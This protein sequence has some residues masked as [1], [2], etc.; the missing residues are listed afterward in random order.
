MWL[1]RLLASMPGG[2]AME[3]FLGETHEQDWKRWE[4]IQ[5]LL[6]LAQDAE[7]VQFFC[8]ELIKIIQEEM[9]EVTPGQN[10]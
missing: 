5:D 2:E 9:G 1:L 4:L 7:D 8:E 10:S 6:N 3:E